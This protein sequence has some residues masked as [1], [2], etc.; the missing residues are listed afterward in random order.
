M[1]ILQLLRNFKM[2][3]TILVSSLLGNGHFY[4][5]VFKF[6]SSV[7]S[8]FICSQKKLNF[9]TRFTSFVIFPNKNSPGAL[10]G[11][12]LVWSWIPT[13]VFHWDSEMA[14]VF[15]YQWQG[16]FQLQLCNDIWISQLPNN[17]LAGKSTSSSLTG[18]VT[19]RSDNTTI[20]NL[21][22]CQL[23]FGCEVSYWQYL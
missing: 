5:T 1:T 13:C 17:L 10:K 3:F 6:S 22:A 8:I 21:R 16:G 9:Q 19:V 18:L 15:V 11:C 4:I 14:L 23:K 7:K 20:S 2:C 12:E